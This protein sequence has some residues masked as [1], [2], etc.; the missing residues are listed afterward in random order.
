MNHD[1]TFRHPHR[2]F[3]RCLSNR[4][5]LPTQIADNRRETRSAAR[6]PVHVGNLTTRGPCVLAGDRRVH[7][8]SILDGLVIGAAPSV[9]AVDG[10]WDICPCGRSTLLDLTQPREQ[11]HGYRG[12]Q[13]RH[14][15]VTHGPYRW[16]RH[17]FYGSAAL[18][19]VASSLVVS[20][21]FLLLTGGLV[22]VLL[23]VR[24]RT[25][26]EKLLARFG[27]AYRRYTERTGRFLPNLE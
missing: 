1:Q 18:L 25:E 13:E 23:V 15:L 9:A 12:H 2:R 22:L 8:Q 11:S 4:R 5:L 21:W 7:G 19:V 16:V 14:T 17:P 26:E 10:S 27:D 6:G 24:T 3:S 20:N